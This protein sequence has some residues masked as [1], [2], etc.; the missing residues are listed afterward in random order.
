MTERLLLKP[1]EA[2]AVLGI[3]RSKLY[4]LLQDGELDS[5]RIG[6]CRRIPIEALS[7]LVRK[8]REHPESDTASERTPG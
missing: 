4:E 6:A 5:V 7:E 2:A 8:L 3:G 1:T